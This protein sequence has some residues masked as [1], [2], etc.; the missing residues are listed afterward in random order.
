[1]RN[2]NDKTPDMIRQRC[3]VQDGWDEKPGLVFRHGSTK[4]KCVCRHAECNEWVLSTFDAELKLIDRKI[5][6]HMMISLSIL[7]GFICGAISSISFG[8]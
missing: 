3:V 2:T 4:F 6:Y 7:F 5:Q 8:G 1:M